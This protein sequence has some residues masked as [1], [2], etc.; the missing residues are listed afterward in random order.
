MTDDLARIQCA[1]AYRQLKKM[2][3]ESTLRKQETGFV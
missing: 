2:L 3:P 1:I